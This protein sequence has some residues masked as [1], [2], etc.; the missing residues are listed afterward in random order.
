MSILKFM[1]KV[2]KKKLSLNVGNDF[3]INLRVFLQQE[4][5]EI[6]IIFIILI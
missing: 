5:R 2:E 1:D 6:K 3:T 4:K